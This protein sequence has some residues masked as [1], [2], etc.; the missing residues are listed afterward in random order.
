MKCDAAGSLPPLEESTIATFYHLLQHRCTESTLSSQE[1]GRSRESPLFLTLTFGP[2]FGILLLSFLRICGISRRISDAWSVLRRLFK[3]RNLSRLETFGGCRDSDLR[4][5]IPENQG[6]PTT[7]RQKRLKTRHLQALTP[8]TLISYQPPL[9]VPKPG[10][11]RSLPYQIPT[12]GLMGFRKGVRARGGEESRR[13][14]EDSA[15]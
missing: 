8:S 4:E 6:Q 5:V 10:E 11:C 7:E 9:D 12:E 15:L 13:G 2:F 1:D 14:R 3:N